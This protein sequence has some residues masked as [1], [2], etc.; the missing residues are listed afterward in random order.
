MKT[1]GIGE[2]AKV[3]GVKPY[4]I[5]YWESELPLLAPR[6][7]PSGRRV[8]TTREVELL[9]RFKTLLYGK[10]FTVEGAKARIW[11]ELG[12]TSPDVRVKISEIRGEMIDLLVRL[13]GRK[14]GEMTES[15]CREKLAALGH[16]RL[17]E[18]WEDRPPEMKRRLLEDLE[19]LDMGVLDS[20]LSRLANEPPHPG[21]IRPAPF[22][23]LAESR[24]D[25]AAVRLGEELIR[26]GKTAFLTV[27]GGQGSR[28]GFNGPKGMFPISPIRKLTLFAVFA[29]KLDAARRRYGADIPWLIMTSPQNEDPTREYFERERFFGLGRDSVHFFTQGV[30]PSLTPQGELLLADDGGLFFN[31]NGHGGTLE[32]L[33]ASGLLEEM[34]EKGIEELFYF[35]IDNPL[36]SVPDPVFLGTHRRAGSEMSTKVIRKAFPEDK[37]GTIGILPDGRATVVEYSDLPEDIMHE[38]QPDGSLRFS[39]GSIAVHIL[40]VSLVSASAAGLPLHTARKKVRT[41]N[42]APGGAEIVEREAVKFEMFIFDAIPRAK[43]ALFFETDRAEEFSPVKNKEGIDSVETCVRGQIEKYAA[44]LSGCGLDV[45]RDLQGK[46]QYAAEIGPRFAPDR[47]SLLKKRAELPSVIDHDILLV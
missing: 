43:S 27:A 1:M 15:E 34:E 8:Y 23:A 10:K 44:W 13:Q 41:L 46:P 21:R 3:L 2:V 17:F 39:H 16:G 5:R 38:K 42:P 25:A 30:L 7:S 4:I 29:E 32:A 12:D 22:V 18:Y 36:V 6:K 19:S 45:P 14:E 11:E 33:R 26:G 40:N 20:L 35:Q 37:L 31:P 47:G 28:L 24:D 9:M